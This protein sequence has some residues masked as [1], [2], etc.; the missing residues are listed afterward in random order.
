M[1]LGIP[2]LVSILFPDDLSPP[3][4]Y[5]LPPN[6]ELQK[7]GNFANTTASAPGTGN[8]ERDERYRE[9]IKKRL[10]K[11]DS[12]ESRIVTGETKGLDLLLFTQVHGDGFLM[13]TEMNPVIFPSTVNREEDELRDGEAI[14]F[15]TK[16]TTSLSASSRL[17][18][19]SSIVVKYPS[20]F[21]R[22]FGFFGNAHHD[23]FEAR[24]CHRLEEC[25][26]AYLV[27]QGRILA[28]WQRNPTVYHS[29]SQRREHFYDGKFALL[30]I[31]SA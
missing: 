5:P 12:L 28:I 20:S 18:R 11:S 15:S 29:L 10:A 23:L 19:T 30:T 4:F 14:T 2:A 16:K 9:M 6:R 27:N 22:N 8:Y 25:M 24:V 7:Y 13:E 21:R 17:P 26:H 1:I 31:L 3:S